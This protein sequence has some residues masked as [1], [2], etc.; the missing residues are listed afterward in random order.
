MTTPGALAL[1]A[2]L[3]AAPLV[4]LLPFDVGAIRFHG[5]SLEWWFCGV[6]API[7]A[8]P[9]AVAFVSTPAPPSE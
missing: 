2:L 3:A 9:L 5:L 6:V 1:L 7:L 4:A 8:V